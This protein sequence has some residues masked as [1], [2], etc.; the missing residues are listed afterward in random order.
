M[1]TI[2]LLSFGIISE[3]IDPDLNEIQF[4]QELSVQEF[5]EALMH[6][7][8]ELKNHS[9]FTIAINETYAQEDE[10]IKDGDQIALIPPVAGG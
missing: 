3:I 5:K 2:Q 4:E 6:F 8:P 10:S 1:V 9:N 7:F